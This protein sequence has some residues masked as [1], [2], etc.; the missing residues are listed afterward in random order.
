MDEFERSVHSYI[1]RHAL[2][3]DGA[4]VVVGLSGGADSVALLAVLA[5]TGYVCVAVHCNYHLRGDESM[6]DRMVA[7][8]VACRLGCRIVTADFHPAG[9]GIEAQCRDMRYALYDK[10]LSACGAEAVAVGHHIEDNV[11]TFLFNALRGG[12]GLRGLKGMMPRRGH[13]VRPLLGVTRDEI[14][15]YLE[16]R[17]LPWVT[18]SSNDTNDYARNRIR[19]I[20]T[21]AIRAVRGDAVA[22]I[23]DTI[24]TLRDNY[25][26]MT[27]YIAGLR[28][29]Y[30]R[31]DGG[32]DVATLAACERHPRAALF[33]LLNDRDTGVG[34]RFSLRQ[35]EDILSAV[36]AS[37]PRRFEA[38]DG[39][40]R[41][42]E[43]GV[44]RPLAGAGVT[45][46]F[47]LAGGLPGVIE[48]R[49]IG[50]SEF[51]PVRDAS[52]MYLDADAVGGDAVAT[53]R[54]A[55]AG[56]RIE[57]FG[58]TGSRLVADI[59]HDAKLSVNHRRQS[60]VLEYSGRVLWVLGLRVSRHYAVTSDT[61]RILRLEIA[62]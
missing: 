35:T 62:R 11:E 54:P 58:M 60:L 33:E 48:A 30:S 31:A 14:E 39:T 38:A 12:A 10:V 41:V 40:C 20:V 49:L 57:P 26:L 21:P 45:R 17:S 15:A 19:H 36:T 59:Y 13:V 42:M 25:A 47:R 43:H 52:F 32:L 50:S 46:S 6:R 3:R 37:E 5:A 27:D 56:D 7:E 34:N 16:R 2:L 29:Q 4:G 28:R 9:S 24:D 23:S 22:R 51:N 61:H 8:E 55:R 18:D 44:L 1:V 53:L